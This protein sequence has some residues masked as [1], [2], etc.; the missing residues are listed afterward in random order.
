MQGPQDLQT[1]TPG[2]VDHDF[3]GRIAQL[4]QI[5]EAALSQFWTSNALYSNLQWPHSQSPLEDNKCS[6][7][8][9]VREPFKVASG[10][11]T[12]LQSV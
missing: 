9:Q 11:E 10:M 4:K 6:P 2:K 12:V 1:Y 7:M 5:I 8:I 3:T